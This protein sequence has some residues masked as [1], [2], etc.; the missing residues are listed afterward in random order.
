MMLTVRAPFTLKHSGTLAAT[1]AVSLAFAGCVVLDLAPWL[2]GPAP[3][4]PEWQWAY[5][6]PLAEPPAAAAALAALA[7]LL[8]AATGLP[9]VRRRERTAARAL[10]LAAVVLGF[11]LPLALLARE[12]AGALRTLLARTT[13][14]SITSYHSAALADDARDPLAFV[15]R[16][17]E[18]LPGLAASAK[19]AATHPAGPV[20]YFRAANAACERWP[21]LTDALLGAVGLPEREF[22]PPLTRPARAGALLGALGLS[23]LAAA[24]A[25]P[26]A[27]LAR[28]LGLPPLAAARAAML[29]AV[30]PGAALVAPRFD[31]AIALPVVTYAWLVARAVRGR[32][33]ARALAAGAGGG[34]ALLLSYGSA[35]FLVAAGLA[36][37]A[38]ATTAEPGAAPGLARRR[39]VFTVG[40]SAAVAVGLAFGVPAAL[41]GQPL[42]ALRTSL[43]IHH[44]EYTAPRS[45]ALWL[46]FDPLDFAALAGVP[47]VALAVVAAAR[48]ALGGRTGRVAAP[49]GVFALV[50]LGALAALVVSGAAR[51]E[52][53]RLWLPL[54]PLALVSAAAAL[55]T[56]DARPATLVA[57]LTTTCT[58]A[59]A[60][61]WRL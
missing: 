3:Y 4:P 27:G 29:W 9:A 16:H 18:L 8:V 25:W 19:H 36:A 61:A 50:L 49:G 37:A 57:A 12:P 55:D 39:A 58:L 21:A 26:L 34:L 6:Q 13:S 44:G 46:L 47:I 17:A 32:T 53:G 20:L 23:L 30:V 35:A 51:G 22:A 52:V 2:R 11:A 5:R 7:V 28:A 1:T 56:E 60:A 59:V 24:T 41:G 33:L 40:A 42:E 10:A 43:A 31:A 48:A 45:Y 54:A 15:R 38:A 14:F